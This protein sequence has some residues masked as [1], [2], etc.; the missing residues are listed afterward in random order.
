MKTLMRILAVMVVMVAGCVGQELRVPSTAFTRGF[1]R[2]VD[3]QAARTTLSVWTTN[4][5]L[6]TNYVTF[7]MLTAGVTNAWRTDVTNFVILTNTALVAQINTVNTNL[8]ARLVSTND[9]LAASINTVNTNL[10]ARLVSTNDILAASINTVATNRLQNGATN[11]SFGFPFTLTNAVGSEM[12]SVAGSGELHLGEGGGGVVAANGFTAGATSF[13][14]TVS[15]VGEASLKSHVVVGGNLL[16]TNGT[17]YLPAVA[18]PTAEGTGGIFWNSNRVLYW[19]T[20]TK[21]NL[22]NDGR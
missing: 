13:L 10:A 17:L 20:S 1:M 11:V 6:P 8:A 4:A 16:L 12:I 19:V 7:A 9:I 2:A 14:S 21:T 5:T 22:L 18:K 15:V 3:A